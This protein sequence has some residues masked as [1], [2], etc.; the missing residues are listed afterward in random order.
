[1]AAP[2]PGVNVPV[3]ACWPAALMC[4]IWLPVSDAPTA[5]ITITVGSWARK[6]SLSVEFS[7]APPETTMQQR[8]QV[9]RLA[10]A[11]PPASSWSTSGRPKASPTISRMLHL[12]RSMVRQHV[13][14]VEAD[15]VV[16][17]ARSCCRR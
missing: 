16:L 17:D 6:R 15:D 3:L 11:R 1:M 14:G 9:V 4:D 12:S 13:V 7:G 10:L 8:R 5:S 2:G